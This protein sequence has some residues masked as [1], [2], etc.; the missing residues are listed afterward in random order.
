MVASSWSRW[1]GTFSRLAW[2]YNDPHLWFVNCGNCYI[3]FLTSI[4][5][6]DFL[7]RSTTLHRFLWGTEFHLTGKSPVS[8]MCWMSGNLN[9]VGPLSRQIGWNLKDRE[10]QQQE[11]VLLQA[12][13]EN[14]KKNS[15]FSLLYKRDAK[16]AVWKTCFFCPKDSRKGCVWNK[17]DPSA[18][19]AN[20]GPWGCERWAST[21]GAG[22]MK[23]LK[24]IKRHIFWYSF[25]GLRCW[26]MVAVFNALCLI[27]P[28]QSLASASCVGHQ[29]A[30]SWFCHILGFKYGA[31]L[32]GVFP[33]DGLNL[34][35]QKIS[36]FQAL[37]KCYVLICIVCRCV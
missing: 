28:L 37:V 33:D 21:S 18:D 19:H 12:S 2:K 1:L 13:G 8:S 25:S 10:A 20:H 6:L 16:D 36:R 3:K 14:W 27:V 11:E 26:K 4:Q 34:K 29:A 15:Y 17:F 30:V 7:A 35:P 9:N 32:E 31:M 5:S 24:L 22:L 23:C